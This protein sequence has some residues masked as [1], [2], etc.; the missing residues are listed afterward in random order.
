MV[1]GGSNVAIECLNRTLRSVQNIYEDMGKA[2]PPNLY[3]QADNCIK[4]N[5][6]KYVFGYF[7]QLVESKVFDKI[8]YNFLL[9]GHTHTDIDQ[10]RR[11]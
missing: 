6:N 4:D 10:V 1:V 2:L 9:K 5:K 7:S 11:M 8:K 3:I